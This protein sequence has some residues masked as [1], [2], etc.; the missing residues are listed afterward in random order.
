MLAGP[1]Q[2][3]VQTLAGLADAAYSYP[4]GPTAL[5]GFTPDA[6][7]SVAFVPGLGSQPFIENQAFTFVNS[8]S[9]QVVIAISGTFFGHGDDLAFLKNLFTDLASFPSGNPTP[10]LVA[11]FLRIYN[12]VAETR[13]KYPDAH[14]TLTGHSLGG[15]VAQILGQLT[16]YDAVGFNAPG[17]ARLTGSLGTALLAAQAA[18]LAASLPPGNPGAL[19]QNNNYRALGDAISVVPLA[20]GTTYTIE[21]LIPGAPDTLA[22]ALANHSITNLISQR[23]YT[24]TQI[25]S[26]LIEPGSPSL[27]AIAPII[28]YIP[29]VG[30]SIIQFSF[31]ANTVLNIFDPSSG[32][33]RR[34]HTGG[35]V[36]RRGQR[37][38]ARLGRRA[39]HRQR[40]HGG[41][42]DCRR[43]CVANRTRRRDG[44][45][46]LGRQ[47]RHVDAVRRRD[48]SGP[49]RRGRGDGGNRVR[50]RRNR[51]R[52]GQRRHVRRPRARK[53][54]RHADIGGGR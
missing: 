1:G 47:W 22:G 17:G 23:G 9:T 4:G 38:R 15:T 53:R 34:R 31:E 35:L 11:S 49:R 48:R 24:G 45:R 8:D 6:G 20:I 37:T 30:P 16:G 3:T 18:G 33:R 7:L 25:A 50:V 26:G 39:V 40:R 51:L 52:R 19:G 32:R 44:Q 41:V 36:R 5:D 43:R 12:L 28:P 13:A 46:R 14:I 21:S 2:P 27:F 10:G 42:D 29:V 54:V